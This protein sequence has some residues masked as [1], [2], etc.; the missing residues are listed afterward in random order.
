MWQVFGEMVQRLSQVANNK[1]L[2]VTEKL[3]RAG[4]L[5]EDIHR[6]AKEIGLR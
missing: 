5:W 2:P 4:S 1:D 3:Q 6:Y